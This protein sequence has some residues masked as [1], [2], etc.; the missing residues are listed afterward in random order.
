MLAKPSTCH[1]HPPAG[2]SE[3]ACP[4]VQ[5]NRRWM[6]SPTKPG[7]LQGCSRPL[8]PQ[9]SQRALA[10]PC[11]YRGRHGPGSRSGAP[12]NEVD[13]AVEGAR[14]QLM[15]DKDVLAVLK[16]NGL[17]LELGVVVDPIGIA[18]A[19]VGFDEHQLPRVA[20]GNPA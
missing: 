16:Q 4:W 18:V 8:P 19:R 17:L 13:G 7:G 9:R 1:C 5:S 20:D 15:S 6:S 2:E 11:R 3:A 14:G 10:P 12:V